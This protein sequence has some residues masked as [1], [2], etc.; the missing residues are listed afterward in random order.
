MARCSRRTSTPRMACSTELKPACDLTAS[1]RS[2]RLAG[3]SGTQWSTRTW[4]T[5]DRVPGVAV[6]RRDR[7]SRIQGANAG[8]VAG[9]GIHGGISG[10]NAGAVVHLRRSAQVRKSPASSGTPPPAP[11][12]SSTAAN[13]DPSSPTH[14]RR[15]HGRTLQGKLNRIAEEAY[16]TQRPVPGNLAGT[17]YPAASA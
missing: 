13:Y 10:S 16:T 5:P 6:V 9:Q 14:R 4:S 8:S 15:N 7:P 3:S 11:P 12:K 17:H 1:P 2:R